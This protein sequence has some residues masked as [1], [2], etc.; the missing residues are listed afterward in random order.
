MGGKLDCFTFLIIKA[1]KIFEVSWAGF[2][3][4][5]TYKDGSVYFLDFAFEEME[6][7]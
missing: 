1:V 2:L 7:G 5:L 3:S 6:K 4:H